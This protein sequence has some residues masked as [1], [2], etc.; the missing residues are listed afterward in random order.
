MLANV[1]KI[2]DENIGLNQILQD[3]HLLSWA[4]KWLGDKRVL[5]ADQ[6]NTKD[7]TDDRKILKEL[8]DLIDQADIVVTHNGRRF[9]QKKIQAR[10]IQHGMQP[11]SSVKHIDTFVLAKKHFGFTSNKLE[12]LTDKLCKAKKLAHKKFPGFELWK[13]CVAGNPAAWREMELYNKHDVLALEEL[14]LK[15]APWDKSN[16]WVYQDEAKCKCGSEQ[17]IKNGWFY[18]ESRKYQ[19]YKC[20]D[21]GYETRARESVKTAAQA[22]T[23]R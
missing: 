8:W 9:D 6:R 1:W 16:F 3:W 14:Y 11:P 19:R 21:C 10:F 23:T 12:F 15:I 5:Y 13:E 7:I 2:W 4:A 18:T 22:G 17:I 20:K